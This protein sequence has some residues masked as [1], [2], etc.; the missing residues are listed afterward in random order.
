[1]KKRV[2]AAA[3]AAVLALLGV[4]V[5]V[6]W[7]QAADDRAYAGAKRQ[8]VL[9]VKDAVGAGTKV[10]EMESSLETRKLPVDA[11][12]DGAVTDL[13]SVEGLTTTT[14]L[15]P[16]EMLLASRLG[17]PGEKTSSATSVPAGLQEISVAV[18]TQHGVGG[19]VKAGDHVGVIGTFNQ[20]APA[21][22]FIVQNVLV[23]GV[24]RAVSA[25]KDA[26]GLVVTLAVGTEEAERVAHSGEWGKVWLTLENDDTDRGGARRLG[27]KDVLR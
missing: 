22:N 7:A 11:I 13:A 1:M 20:P 18:D 26:T 15:A 25:E 6:M 12:P 3:M 5:L 4:V 23:T 2:V 10:S 9:L 19:A 24:Q 21:T 17:K 27:T 14:S 8:A 16:G